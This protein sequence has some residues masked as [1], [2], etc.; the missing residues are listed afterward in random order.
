M[1]LKVMTV[2]LFVFFSCINTKQT[3]P[4]WIKV[5]INLEATTDTGNTLLT[6]YSDNQEIGFN[7][8]AIFI[9]ANKAELEKDPS[10][11]PSGFCPRSGKSLSFEQTI[12]IR[13]GGEAKEGEFCGL[14]GLN[15]A[16]GVW[17][18]LRAKVERDEQPYSEPALVQVP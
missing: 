14:S 8:Y 2:F 6:F 15:P 12:R 10:S 13:L 3:T 9:N 1:K 4:E 11:E 7:G 16:S 5:P 18:A 17:V